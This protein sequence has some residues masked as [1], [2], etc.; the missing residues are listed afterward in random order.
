MY[1]YEIEETCVINQDMQEHI[2]NCHKKSES[3]VAYPEHST[4]HLNNVAN[5]TVD[6]DGTTPRKKHNRRE[7]NNQKYHD[8]PWEK[9]EANKSIIAS[10]K[11]CQTRAKQ[12]KKLKTI[13]LNK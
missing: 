1:K 8:I 13:K 10:E 9:N 7:E 12:L 4:A 3:R 11:L 5:I 6:S 2:D